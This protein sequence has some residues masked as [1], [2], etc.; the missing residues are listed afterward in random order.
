MAAFWD[1]VDR[2]F[3]KLAS[4]KITVF[5]LV[6]LLL[7]SIPGTLILQI[8][9]SNVDPALEYEYDFW[10]FGQWTQLFT[11]YHSFWYV[12]LIVILSM[13]LIACSVE[14][15]P[16]MWKMASAKPVAWARETFLRQPASLLHK[17]EINKQKAN[18]RELESELLKVAKSFSR[19]AC[20]TESTSETFQIFFQTGQWSRISNYLVHTSLL[21]IF[22]G[23]I[24]SSMYGF[25]GAINIPAGSAVDSFIV[26][27]E[28]K[29]AGLQPV[30]NGLVNEKKLGFKLAATDFKVEFYKDYPGRPKDFVSWLEVFEGNTS[31]LKKETRVNDP[32]IYKNFE[33]YQASYGRLGDY[34]IKF[35]MI[36]KKDPENN[37][38]YIRSRLNEIQNV[39][40]LKITVVPLYAATNL[41]GL[42]PAVQFTQVSAENKAVGE[43][44]WVFQEAP[45]Y[46]FRREVP[47]G[48]VVDEVKEIYFTGLQ[49]G[50]DPGS[51][52]YWLGCAGLLLGTFYALFVTH[53]KYFLR[54]E[55]GE[56]YF[57]GTIHRLPSGFE[58]K[59]AKIASRFL[60]ASKSIE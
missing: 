3:L 13:N 60:H 7:L 4:V 19:K 12:G 14:R 17:W 23:A 37:I 28:G 49:I 41:R 18:I 40:K 15:W 56:F 53:K 47:W 5:I 55:N 43:P 24:I 29:A 59:V 11:A 44:F 51:P 52:I 26:F 27:K 42:G 32:L 9:M 48:V 21:V 8:N 58:Q 20:V 54:Y 57:S 22:A 16:G 38:F 33:F 1:W 39:E 35:R 46:D 2:S 31:V 10:K 30:P 45:L 6:G 34:D 25:E 50:Y 36:G